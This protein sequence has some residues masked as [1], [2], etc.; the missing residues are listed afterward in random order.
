[1][2][3]T[4]NFD[5]TPEELRHFLGLPNVEGLQ[6][7]MLKMA[8]EQLTNSGQNMFNDIVAGAVQPMMAYQQWLQKMMLGGGGEWST[9]GTE[10]NE[11]A[12][13]KGKSATRGK[14]KDSGKS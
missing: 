12:K 1:M 3:I 10:S 5:V 13:D 2:K 7:E 9:G 8:Q 11:A 14:S 6:A 4:V